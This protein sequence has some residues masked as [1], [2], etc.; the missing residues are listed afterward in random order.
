MALKFLYLIICL[1]F[2]NICST[3][4]A[5]KKDDDKF[6][7]PYDVSR[8]FDI[9]T[10]T[11]GLLPH[12]T[13]WL[14]SA[15]PSADLKS[16][17]AAVEAGPESK[18]ICRDSSSQSDGFLSRLIVPRA[19]LGWRTIS[20]PDWTDLCSVEQ[21]HY[22]LI[23]KEWSD[24]WVTKYH[25]KDKVH[26]DLV[27]T[28]THGVATTKQSPWFY[29]KLKQ[30]ARE[31]LT[32]QNAELAKEIAKY[33]NCPIPKKSELKNTAKMVSEV[34]SETAIAGSAPKIDDSSKETDDSP[35]G[36]T[37]EKQEVDDTVKSSVNNAVS[38]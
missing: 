29:F 27:R 13:T 26:Y 2:L 30:E 18:V 7:D 37:K 10:P 20:R 14:E 24:D 23:R 12:W 36:K 5:G 15:A 3:A 17:I 4:F 33:P 34:V 28:G 6:A 8:V 31:M 25:V 16:C 38:K 35:R 19:T 21:E 22:I 9:E 11:D 32:E 1:L